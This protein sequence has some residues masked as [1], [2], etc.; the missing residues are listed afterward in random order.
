MKLKFVFVIFILYVLVFIGIYWLAPIL[1]LLLIIVSFF[2]S[3]NKKVILL[4]TNALFLLAYIT[5]F[6]F[7]LAIFIRVFL[8]DFFF[9]P[10]SS[11]ENNLLVGDNIIVSK[12][13][14]GP[15]LPQSPF[16]IPW[17]NLFFYLNNEA[18][19]AMDSTWYDYKRLSGYSA[20]KKNDIVVFNNPNRHKEFYIK[21]CIGLPG[22]KIQIINAMVYDDGILQYGNNRVKLKYE[23]PLKSKTLNPSFTKQNTTN[24]ISK[25]N[26]TDSVNIVN[27]EIGVINGQKTSWS[28][29]DWGPVTVPK[30]NMTI[31][32]NSDNFF[33]YKN[34][35]EN[36]EH[37]DI[38]EKDDQIFIN[39]HSFTKYTFKQNYYFMMGDNRNHS[40]DSRFWGFVPEENI[41]GKAVMVLYS[42]KD[43]DID[44][45]R[46]FKPIH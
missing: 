9:I 21:R 28:I 15:K 8:I 20:I 30:K 25:N 17:I 12:L 38:T 29:N 40:Y 16:E 5:S 34:I 13:N 22:H 18:Y 43:G 11:M 32:L 10:T 42:E 35:L 2:Y 1:V 31:N 44:W 41:I 45:N 37:L 6:I 14:Y 3:K 7:F 4:R 33:I 23:L 19:S 27:T 36:Y 24:I 26:P 46:L 39:G